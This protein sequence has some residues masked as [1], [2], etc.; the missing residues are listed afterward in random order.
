ML[1]QVDQVLYL[2]LSEGLGDFFA[3]DYIKD[4]LSLQGEFVVGFHSSLTLFSEL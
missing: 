2:V 4:S 1:L 3:F